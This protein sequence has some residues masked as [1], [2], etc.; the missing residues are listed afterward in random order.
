MHEKSTVGI[1]NSIFNRIIR[2]DHRLLGIRTSYLWALLF[3]G[4]VAIWLLSGEIV[5]GGRDNSAEN[6]D[7]PIPPTAVQSNEKKKLFKVQTRTIRARPRDA[8]LVLRGRTE[9]E[10]MVSIM[11]ETSGVVER[12]PV[13]KGTFVK[14]GTLLCQIEPAARQ[15]TVEQHKAALAKARADAR[16]SSKLVKRGYAGKLKVTSDAALV[17]AAR[18][19]YER[20][21]LDLDRTMIKA[22]FSGIVE[23]MPSKI[24]DYLVAGFGRDRACAKM[25]DIDPLIIV[26]AV[27]ERD[28]AA[29]KTGMQAQIK[30]V[31]G[32]QVS[33]EIRYIATAA[34]A[35]TRTFRTE[36]EVAN[37]DWKLRDGVTA[38]ITIPLKA[39]PAHHFSPA[40]LALNDAG[41]IGVRIVDDNDT[42]RFID[43]K[44]LANDTD[45][46]WVSGL[47]ERVRIITV[48]QEY[49]TAGQKVIPKEETAFSASD[50]N[51]DENTTSIR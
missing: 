38:D 7:L 22:P 42:V 35:K 49:V 6:G 21:R 1:G 17:N 10:A 44:I 8:S 16:A 34:D 32:E 28:I 47:P 48:G 29:L 2:A 50:R 14:K 33:G 26:T 24:G 30:L 19:A 20:A 15:A 40:I 5:I 36:I 45:G 51:G 23:D 25:V 11:A 12:T 4:I 39:A 37:T 3:T 46:V 13:K 41:Q 27:S 43:I 31:T 9:A 18:A